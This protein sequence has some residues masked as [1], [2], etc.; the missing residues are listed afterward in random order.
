MTLIQGDGSVRK[1][2]LLCQ[3]YHTIF[4]QFGW[5]FLYCWDL[6][7]DE[8]HAELGWWTSCSAYFV[9]LIFQGRDPFMC[10]FIKQKQNFSV[11]LCSD[12][13]RHIFQTWCD[14]ILIS[15]W[16]TLTFIQSQ[17]CEKSKTPESIFLETSLSIWMKFSVLP[18]SVALLKL[19]LN[20]FCTSNIQGRELCWHDFM[21]YVM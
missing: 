13:S 15:V 14:A 20:L 16:M 3:L 7:G 10:N 19:M 8:L 1:E 12:I 9:H 4:N 18:Q 6:L 17:L 5:K 2:K 21:K 11:G